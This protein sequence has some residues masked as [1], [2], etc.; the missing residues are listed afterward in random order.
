MRT[1]ATYAV[2]SGTVLG[3]LIGTTLAFLISS[4]FAARIVQAFGGWN[5]RNAR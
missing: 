5:S 2:D 3:L 1:L 4:V